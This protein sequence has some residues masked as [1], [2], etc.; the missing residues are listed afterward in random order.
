MNTNAVKTRLKSWKRKSLVCVMLVS[1]TA[2]VSCLSVKP[3]ERVSASGWLRLQRGQTFT[4]PR[5]MMLAEE[6]VVKDLQD[7]LIDTIE[8]LRKAEVKASI[9]E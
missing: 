1:S 5:D 2:L 7:E 3:V 9:G 6:Y 4:A 8:A